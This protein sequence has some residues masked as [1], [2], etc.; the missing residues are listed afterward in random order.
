M[1]GTKLS[2]LSGFDCTL[3]KSKPNKKLKATQEENVTEVLVWID[4][5][6]VLSSEI[7]IF[8]KLSDLVKVRY[9]VIYLKS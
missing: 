5:R 9:S 4:F 1:L 7:L 6:I 3:K 2:A 8:L